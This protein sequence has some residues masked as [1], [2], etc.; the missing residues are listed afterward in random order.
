[1]RPHSILLVDDHY[2][3]REALRGV[4]WELEDEFIVVESSNCRQMMKIIEENADIE[5]VLLDVKLP[6]GCGLDAMIELRKRRPNISV[7]F[8]SAVEDRDTIV[9]AL[10]LGARGFLPKSA[11]REVLLKAL[12]LMFS[13]GRY[14]PDVILSPEAPPGR[15]ITVEEPNRPV[16]SPYDLGLTDAQIKV[17]A[18]LMQGQSNKNICRSLD[19]KEPTVKN[20]VTGI[21]R[22]LKAGNRTDAAVKANKFNWDLSEFVDTTKD[23]ISSA[24]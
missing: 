21:L 10:N 22:A 23:P 2:L 20:H 7:I 17:L 4:L 15:S 12:Q 19:L 9:S 1:M 8:M 14:V 13:G 3:I 16:V 6:D 24:R 5:T 11:D 18:L